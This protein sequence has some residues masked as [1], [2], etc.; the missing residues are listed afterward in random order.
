[1]GLR[2]RL[3]AAF[4]LFPGLPAPQRRVAGARQATEEKIVDQ[5]LVVHTDPSLGNTLEWERS[6]LDRVGAILR[7]ADCK[8]VDDIIAACRDSDA[9]LNTVVPIPARAIQAMSRCQVIV[10][11]G[12]GVD[13]VDVAAATEAGI[14]V[15]NV[16][17]ASVEEVSNHALALLLACSRKIVRLDRALRAGVW[18]R[19]MLAPMG[20]VYGE[21]LGLVGFGRIARALARKAQALGMHVIATDP[22]VDAETMHAAGVRRVTL[23][24]LLSEADF[25]SLHA[26]LT[27]ETRHI[28]GPAQLARMKRSACLIN[29][30]RGALVDHAALV[31]ALRDGAIAAAGLDVFDQEPLGPDHPLT[32][33]ENVVLTPHVAA[34]SD[35]SVREIRRRAGEAVADVLLGFWPRSVVNPEVRPRRPL[36][37][38]PPIAPR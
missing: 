13:N 6:E 33:L 7:A 28:I 30:A 24:E 4:P 34:F 15:A 12:V 37:P 18:D 19:S 31:H 3:W 35:A 22:F 10:R 17:D 16:P 8:T 5:F 25:I 32:A 20:T 23:D 14:V 36:Q 29:T 26:P 27:P 9:V 21:T 1:M 11:T 2:L 38:R